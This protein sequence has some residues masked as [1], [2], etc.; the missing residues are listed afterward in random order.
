MGHLP[1][2]RQPS[3]GEQRTDSAE[4]IACTALQ[5]ALDAETPDLQLRFLEIAKA[6]AERK[7]AIAEAEKSGLD[8]KNASLELRFQKTRFWATTLTPVL[9][10]VIT[11]VTLVVTVA[12]Q[13]WQFRRTTDSQRDASEDSQWRD[14]LGKVSFADSN[15]ALAASFAM[16]GFLVQNATGDK[17]VRLRQPCSR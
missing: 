11:A 16:Q 1:E 15:S 13:T 2:V 17:L 5:R 12:V 6:V 3:G 10:V 7:K 8:A 14:A 4:S 9:A